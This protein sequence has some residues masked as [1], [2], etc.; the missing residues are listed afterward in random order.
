MNLP[1]STTLPAHLVAHSNAGV[2]FTPRARDTADAVA[3]SRE[4]FL[5]QSLVWLAHPK[6][7]L[8]LEATWTTAQEVTGPGRTARIR[9]LLVA[10]GV[11]G[12]IDF[13][14]GLQI[15]PGLAFPIGVGPSQ[16]ERS[17]FAYLSFEHPFAKRRP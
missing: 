1:F 17:V 7:N 8:M 11:R 4:Y 13:A 10:P 14:S 3:T 5:G 6:L 15:V 9:E 2:S 12:A 16:G